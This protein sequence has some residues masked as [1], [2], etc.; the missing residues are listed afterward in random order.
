MTCN[1]FLLFTLF[2]APCEDDVQIEVSAPESI[3]ETD[4]NTTVEIC[5]RLAMESEGSG[6]IETSLFLTTIAGTAGNAD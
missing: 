4:S 5:A 6:M 1:F 3:L 2:N